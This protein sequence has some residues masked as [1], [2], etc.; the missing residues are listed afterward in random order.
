LLLGNNKDRIR[1]L[2]LKIKPPAPPLTTRRGTLEGDI[3][4]LHS[5]TKSEPDATR[6]P[7]GFHPAQ[8]VVKTEQ[9]KKRL[10]PNVGLTKMHKNAKESNGVGVQVQK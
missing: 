4:R 2:D 1:I 9:V 10:Y 5:V 7:I 8:L 6:H 3:A